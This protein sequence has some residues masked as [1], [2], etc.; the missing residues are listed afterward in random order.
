MHVP[1]EDAAAD[2]VDTAGSVLTTRIAESD[3]T[4]PALRY[5]GV[6]LDELVGKVPFD[7][8]WGLLVREDLG[9]RLPPAEVHP[10][11][12]RTG[13]LRA[14]V[15]S[16]LATLAPVWG[17]RPLHDISTDEALDNL[18]RASVLTLSFVAQ[19]ARGPELPVVPQRVVDRAGSVAERFLVRWRGEADPTHVEALDAYMVAAAE[20]G[21][22]PSTLAARAVASTGADVASCMSAAVGAVSGPMHGGAT[23]RVLRMLRSADRRGGVCATI[24]EVLDSGRPLLGFGHAIYRDAEDPRARA[25]REVCR[26][27]DSARYEAAREVEAEALAVLHERYPDVAIATTLD[28]WAAVVLDV[29]QVPVDAFSALFACARTAGWSAHIVEQKETGAVIRPRSVYTGPEPRR[30]RDVNGA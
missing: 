20:H 28:F 21:F 26:R 11:P 16:A 7:R 12:A 13:S 15:Q 9:Y 29:A 19:S 5:R 30:L 22:S 10:L 17:F 4:T 6:D 2:V 1:R 27:L 24:I 18:A 25:I 14:D 8:V 3:P 23:S